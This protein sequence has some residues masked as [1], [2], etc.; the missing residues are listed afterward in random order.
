MTTTIYIPVF[1]FKDNHNSYGYLQ[2]L[3]YHLFIICICN[4]NLVILKFK[5]LQSQIVIIINRNA[6]IKQAAS[7]HLFCIRHYTV[8][9]VF[10]PNCPVSFTTNGPSSQLC[11]IR[12]Y[13]V[14]DL[15]SALLSCLSFM[16]NIT[17]IQ[18]YSCFFTLF[19]NISM[20]V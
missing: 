14:A 10:G 18:I 13:Y 12:D 9:I 3:Q 8:R 17:I 19:T 2:Y 20:S 6:F 16:L 11:F 15:M 7:R 1:V 5:F 4:L